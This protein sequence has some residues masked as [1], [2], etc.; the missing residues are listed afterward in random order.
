[1]NF[2]TKKLNSKIAG[3]IIFVILLSSLSPLF[4]KKAEAQWIV[5]D[6]GAA[7]KEYGL[8][9]VG[10]IIINLIIERMSKST[11]NWINGG[12]KGKPAFISNPE[13]FF[14][15]LG[16][17]VAGQLIFSNP[18]T[19]F[20]CGPLQAK[21]RLA[22]TSTYNQ[23][24]T[25]LRCSLTQ[26]GGNLDGFMANFE[27]GGWGTFFE[28]TQKPQNNPIGAYLQAEGEL[29]ETI[30]RK[31]DIAEKDLLQG[32]GF[33]SFKKC[34]RFTKDRDPGNTEAEDLD[35]EETGGEEDELK[36]MSNPCLKE[37]TV[38][39]GSVI[40]DQLNK[41]LGLGSDKLAIADELNEIVSALLNKL[42][43]SVVGGIGK[44]LRGLSRP[45]PVTNNETFTEQLSSNPDGT[46]ASPV[47]DYFGNTPN[48]QI[49]DI[50]IPD[51]FCLDQ[52]TNPN[53]PYYDLNPVSCANPR[54]P[55]EPTSTT[56]P[57]N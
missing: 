25:R 57:V 12:F 29:F 32:K 26:I 54:P 48:T 45:D 4:A 27:N 51:P 28:L 5:W 23:D 33:L 20:L 41:Q 49:L 31:K 40:S 24:S 10:W 9:A 53:A 43:S 38:T 47:V 39:P 8:D 30:A 44:G 36:S 35:E 2:F 19:K 13:A 42:V 14:G 56:T 21:I 37:E 7:A 46:V 18:N 3:L 22:L 55:V 17:Q 52:S 6:P 15:Q 34:A 50:P 16:D 11:V 1:M